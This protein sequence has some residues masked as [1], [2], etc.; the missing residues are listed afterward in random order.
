MDHNDKLA[1]AIDNAHQQWKRESKT[2]GKYLKFNHMV[3]ECFGVKLVGFRDSGNVGCSYQ[4][5]K[6]V[7]QQAYEMFMY[8]YM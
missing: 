5:A 2:G 8:K 6:V 7:D 1:T 3:E 4:Q